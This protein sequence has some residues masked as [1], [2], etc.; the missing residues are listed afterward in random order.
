MCMFKATTIGY[1]VIVF[2]APKG[3]EVKNHDEIEKIIWNTW[4][5]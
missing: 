5:R 4:T 3:E 1:N 2:H